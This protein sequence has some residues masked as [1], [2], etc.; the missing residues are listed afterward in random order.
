[1]VDEQ[2][3]KGQKDDF[4]ELMMQIEDEEIKKVVSPIEQKTEITIAV[5]SRQ[6]SKRNTNQLSEDAQT[7]AQWPAEH[8]ENNNDDELDDFFNNNPKGNSP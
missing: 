6:A 1:M 2:Q 3:E 7:K 8:D 4:E 5:S